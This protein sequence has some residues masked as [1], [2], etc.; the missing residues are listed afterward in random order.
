MKQQRLSKRKARTCQLIQIGGLFHKPGLMEAF[1][2]PS[3][4]D[5]QDYEN[6]EKAAAL[7]GFL[8]TCFENNNFEKANLEEWKLAG[9]RLLFHGC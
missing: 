9:G 6:R 7:L 4:D 8:T 1:S 2:I 3:N 5:P